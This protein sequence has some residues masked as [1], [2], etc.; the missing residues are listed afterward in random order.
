MSHRDIESL[1]AAHALDAVDADE[2]R[3]IET[4]LRICNDSRAEIRALRAVAEFLRT[5]REQAPG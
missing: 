1:L 4:H 2:A 5:G 3:A